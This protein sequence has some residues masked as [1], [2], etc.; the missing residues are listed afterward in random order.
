MSI[1]AVDRVREMSP[2]RNLCILKTLLSSLAMLH[3]V[4]P[5]L[6]TFARAGKECTQGSE[7]ARD[8]TSRLGEEHE[9]AYA[10]AC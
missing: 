7:A 8:G 2:T 1:D 6:S 9:V 10:A 3:G 4:L 5:S